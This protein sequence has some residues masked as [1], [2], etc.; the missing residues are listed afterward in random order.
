LADFIFSRNHEEY[1][2]R[3]ARKSAFLESSFRFT[4]NRPHDG[5]IREIKSDVL[6]H[7]PEKL[8]P[9]HQVASAI[10]IIDHS[11]ANQLQNRYLPATYRRPSQEGKMETVDLPDPAAPRHNGSPSMI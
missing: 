11:R 1:N 3:L 7:E 6:T 9:T 10:S 8:T 2:L 5:S 4:K